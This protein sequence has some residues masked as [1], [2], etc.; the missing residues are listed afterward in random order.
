MEND[1]WRLW[2]WAWAYLPSPRAWLRRPVCFNM[3]ASTNRDTVSSRDS[4]L[5]V[6]LSQSAEGRESLVICSTR[7]SF[8][9]V[10]K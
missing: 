7:Y 4:L 5:R 3:A 1:G 10:K 6:A 8:T 2:A 9:H